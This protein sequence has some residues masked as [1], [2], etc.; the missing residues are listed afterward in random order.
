LGFGG[1]LVG[2]GKILLDQVFTGKTSPACA[3]AGHWAALGHGIGLPRRIGKEAGRAGLEKRK[4][5]GP[6]L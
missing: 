3:R 1:F 4:R 5:F 2:E 6:R